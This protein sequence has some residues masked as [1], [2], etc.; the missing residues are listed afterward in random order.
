MATL[1]SI[2]KSKTFGQK[3]KINP[4]RLDMIVKL[5]Y[6]KSASKW[7]VLG[8]NKKFVL[9]IDLPCDTEAQAL[10]EIETLK[11][12]A[13][14]HA[15][16]KCYSFSIEALTKG[17]EHECTAAKADFSEENI[18]ELNFAIPELSE[19]EA[20]ENARSRVL[21]RFAKGVWKAVNTEEG[22]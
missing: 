5:V 8:I 7:N 9:T 20:F 21:R 1:V 3:S 6:T 17:T 22:E 18:T 12:D 4:S 19:G 10:D 13:E 16:V 14:F 2:E 15:S 11:A